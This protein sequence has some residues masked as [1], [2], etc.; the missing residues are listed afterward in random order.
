MKLMKINSP[1]TLHLF[2]LVP[3]SLQRIQD[4][5]ISRKNG[6]AFKLPNGQIHFLNPFL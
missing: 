4:A 6:G 5:E 1:M 3:F 2:Q